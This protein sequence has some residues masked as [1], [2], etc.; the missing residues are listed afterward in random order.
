MGPCVEHG[1]ECVGIEFCHIDME[2]E[3]RK[4]IREGI[5]CDQEQNLDEGYKCASMDGKL[6]EWLQQAIGTIHASFRRA[7][8]NTHRNGGKNV[9]DSTSTLGYSEEYR[10]GFIPIGKDTVVEFVHSTNT[11]NTASK[12]YT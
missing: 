7:E 9:R 6:H 3:P 1:K 2:S 5:E 12:S 11:A 10:K 4:I 8:E